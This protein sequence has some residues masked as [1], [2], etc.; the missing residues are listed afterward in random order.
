[1]QTLFKSSI[2]IQFD[3]NNDEILSRYLLTPSHAR[4]L[5][6][7]IS[8]CLRTKGMNS[9]IL[10]GP[11]GTGKSLLSSI[12]SKFLS[13]SVSSELFERLYNESSIIDPQLSNLLLESYKSQKKYIPVLINGKSGDLRKIIINSILK[14]LNNYDIKITIPNEIS[15]IIKT[16]EMWKDKFPET[17]LKLEYYLGK[18]GIGY[19]KWK[20]EIEGYNEK[21][22]SEF[23]IFYP[24]VTA[25]STWINDDYDNFIENTKKILDDLN[26]LGLGIV[27]IYDEFGR[28]LQSV[29]SENSYIHL[30]NLQDLAELANSSTNFQLLL[31]NH[32]SIRQY[33]SLDN[34]EYKVEFEKV[35]KRFSHY[36]FENDSDSYLRLA[37][38][39]LRQANNQYDDTS[40][41]I[42]TKEKM[43]QYEFLNNYSMYQIEEIILK[44]MYP[45]HPVTIALL[46]HLSNILGQNERTL[47]SFI[48][49]E[50]PYGLHHHIQ[51][52]TGYYYPDKLFHFFVH[53]EEELL[54]HPIF[55][56]YKRIISNINSNEIDLIRIVEFI[57][58][59]KLANLG[60][61]QRIETSFIAFALGQ[62]ISNTGEFL[63]KLTGLKLIRF[64]E[65]IQQWELYEGSSVD[66]EFAI[67][68]KRS[69]IVLNR[70]KKLE[71]INS[72]NNNKFVLPYEY[73]DDIGM[74]RFA[75]IKFIWLEDLEEMTDDID[76]ADLQ[77]YYVLTPSA[78]SQNDMVFYEGIYVIPNFTTLEVEESL[79]RFA[80]IE[81][82]LNDS[83]F[84]V[85]DE[86]LKNELLFLKNQ[87]SSKIIK[88]INQYHQFNNVTWYENN[89]DLNL[90]NQIELEKTISNRMYDKY[91]STPIIRNE[92]FNR[93][94][95]TGIQRRAAIDVID[96]LIN[97]PDM[98]NIGISG[99]G[100]NYLIYASV[101]KNNGYVFNEE[102]IQIEGP[103]QSLRNAVISELNKNSE[104]NLASLI[105]IFTKPPYG[106]R[107]SV[108]PVLF[109]ALLRDKWD[110]LIIYSHD[111]HIPDL[112]GFLL[113][114]MIERANEYDYKFYL[115]D[116][117]DK[118]KLT[119]LAQVFDID[120]ID[121]VSLFN[122]SNK[123][124]NWLRKLPRFTQQTN[125]LSI[126][127]LDLRDLI[128]SS[129]IDPYR[130]IKMEP[131]DLDSL[132][133]AKQEIESF[134]DHRATELCKYILKLTGCK[135]LAE[136]NESINQKI[137]KTDTRINSKILNVSS[138]FDMSEANLYLSKLI[139]RL[140]GVPL[141]DW[142]DATQ[143]LFLRQFAYEWQIINSNEAAA[144]LET[145]DFIKEVQL[146][147]KSQVLYT[148]VKNLLKYGGKDVTTHE[149][150]YLL[151]KLIQEVE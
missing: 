92:S 26:K 96:H 121:G 22:I 94:S 145:T 97:T 124:I 29:Q 142:S 1:M 95:I 72:L 17:F 105:D 63:K 70:N 107:H 141:C 48:E 38:E 66:I 147:K 5:K 101:L 136:L 137:S 83:T 73:N 9:H 12:I 133:L 45:L 4:A 68:E 119:L 21:L 8:S 71:I 50:E 52:D 13:K 149:L 87:T 100:P 89:V 47:F 65:V 116:G 138:D 140:V 40:Q 10:I 61:K 115:L 88:F 55:Q 58:L 51:T 122:V 103:L 81:H 28:F 11:Y 53:D 60:Q 34:K 20:E 85:K 93:R 98:L 129:E 37:Y 125:Q 19:D 135:N 35:E 150:K 127:A 32:K 62:N 110:Q 41:H 84:I 139:D 69:R 23:Y 102:S 132:L 49:G 77:I 74:I 3:L 2:N 126:T 56:T 78:M 104:G 146:S 46:P 54:H 80:I 43:K 113:Y 134:M 131:I 18:N 24:T 99:H 144:S 57:T 33:I 39:S 112:N 59:W 14:Y 7:V 36:H 86:R 114:E 82:L 117:S 111:M 148:N 27:L 15:S 64:N 106:L 25:G 6:G 76:D 30:Q 90:T 109:V 128:R 42:I 108:V 91:S 31:I 120:T 143:D 44:G 16:T 67:E 130:L 123:L 151:A 75:N 79:H 118:G